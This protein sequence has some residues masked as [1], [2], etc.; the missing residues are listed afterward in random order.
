MEN[1]FDDNVQDYAKMQRRIDFLEHRLSQVEALLGIKKPVE[2]ENSG[3]LLVGY[4]EVP[5]SGKHEHDSEVV[6]ESR[7]GEFGLAWLGSIVLLF[8]IAFITQYIQNTGHPVLS[9]ILGYSA[10]AGVLIASHFIRKTVSA[11]AAKFNVISQVL[12]F[13]VTLRLHFYT[14]YPL[15]SG[16]VIPVTLLL[17]IIGIQFYQSVRRKSEFSA[18]ISS[19]LLMITA[20]ITTSSHFTFIILVVGTGISVFLMFRYSWWKLLLFLQVLVYMSFILWYFESHTVASVSRTVMSDSYGLVY[21]FLCVSAFSLLPLIKPK[22][23]FQAS[24]VFISVMLNGILFSI[25]LAIFILTF[26]TT[27]FIGMFMSISLACL[28]FSVI[29]KKYSEWKYTPAFYALYGFVTLSIAVYG[30]CGMP[31]VFLLLSLQSLLVVSMA[32]WFKSRIIVVMNFFLFISLFAGYLTMSDSIDSINISFALVS[33]ISAR[34]INWK[35]ERLEIKTGLLRNVYMIVGFGAVLF[36]L[37]K[38]VPGNFVTLSWTIAAG[39]YFIL[40][41]LLHNIKYRWMALATLLAAAIYLFII[42]LAKVGILFRIAAF[43]FLAV[44]SLG[45]SLYYAK[46][47]KKGHEQE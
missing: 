29:L 7:I 13:Y 46:R 47:K 38:I 17:I 4:E 27:S 26:Y 18:G 3:D 2:P 12:L 37:Y 1:P 30:I 34:V 44:I 21:L 25:N 11:L 23:N 15:F 22:E 9:A 8:G 45:V 5:V 40:S 31:L 39:V 19:I 35:R 24:V 33:L 32:I 43:M 16:E 28:I 10:V 20:F 14:A 41:I 36:A 42:D 6:M